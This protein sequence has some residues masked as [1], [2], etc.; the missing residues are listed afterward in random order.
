MDT[1]AQR[2]SELIRYHFTRGFEYEEI[3]M[4]MFRGHGVRMSA[5]T[6]LRRLSVLGLKR[7]HLQHDVELVHT[8]IRALIDDPNSFRGCRAMWHQL[9]M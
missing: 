9:Q 5:Q 6:L 2:E 1:K 8:E 4:L 7:R 3:A